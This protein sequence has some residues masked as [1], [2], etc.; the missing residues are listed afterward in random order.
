MGNVSTYRRPGCEGTIPDITLVSEGTANRVNGWKVLEIYTGSDHQYISYSLQAD[1]LQNMRQ[2]QASTRKWNVEKLS[3]STLI[4]KVDKRLENRIISVIATEIVKR[5]MQTIK[6][7]CRKAMPKVKAGFKKQA[8]YWWND[9][10]AELRRI[11][12][13]CRRRLTRARRRS[14][15]DREARAYKKA[16]RELKTAIYTSKWKK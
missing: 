9:E 2:Q 12:L 11:C 5:T 13:S 1:G 7:G 3:K 14:E 8:V 6:H 16:K 10:I 4:E 15:A